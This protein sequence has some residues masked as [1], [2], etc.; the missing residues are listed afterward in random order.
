MTRNDRLSLPFDQGLID[1]AENTAVV[2]IRAM[3]AP[4]YARFGSLICV[5][6]FRPVYDA[7]QRQG[8]PVATELPGDPADLVIVELTR[9][10]AESLGNIAAGYG[11]LPPGGTLVVDGLKTDGVESVLKAVK[12]LLPVA[13][14][15]SKAH[16][17]VFWL[18]K[19][20][21][22]PEFAG[23]ATALTPAEIAG[24]YVTAAGIFSQDAADAGSVLLAPHLGGHLTGKGADLGAGW[25]WLA[26]Q[27]LAGNIGI[28]SLALIEAEHAA[29]GCARRNVTDPRAAFDWADVRTLS[30]PSDHDFVL[31]NPPF[32]ESRKADPDLG[33]QFIQAAARLLHPRGVLWM[34]ANRHLAYE[35]ALGAQFHS[36][37]YLEQTA[38]FK[39]IRA[40]RPKRT[41]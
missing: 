24:G 7:L 30:G 27:A 8:L 26:D 22:P 25:G 11:L 14:T 2:A 20:H 33:R 4:V 6:G 41:S 32:H 15:L 17:K 28:T 40:T 23:W 35:A 38:G 16:G 39:C 1:V 12:K 13:G 3:P 18:T 37:D 36:W 19:T 5:Q 31:M 9:S 34:V 21:T 29:L 10:K